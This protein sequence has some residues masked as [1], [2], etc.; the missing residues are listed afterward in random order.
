MMHPPE[1]EELLEAPFHATVKKISSFLP[2]AH[3]GGSKHLQWPL[4]SS[5]VLLVYYITGC[6]WLS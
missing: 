3:Q 5:S 1:Q 2:I 4:E 6:E